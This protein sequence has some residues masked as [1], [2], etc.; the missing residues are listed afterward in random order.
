MAVIPPFQAAQNAAFDIILKQYGQDCVWE[1]DSGDVTALVLYN[2]PTVEEKIQ[3]VAG[4]GLNHVG[5]QNGE[6]VV[7]YIEYGATTFQGL[8]ESVYE[9]NNEYVRT[10][11]VRY[12]CKKSTSFFDGQT[13][14]L[15]MEKSNEQ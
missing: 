10:G 4:R 3:V 14:Y 2:D 8:F 15:T 12:V 7:P 5:Y 1:K 11:G 13:Y 6:V 9:G